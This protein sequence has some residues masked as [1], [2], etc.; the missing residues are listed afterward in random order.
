LT[1]VTILSMHE[2]GYIGVA[3]LP[4]DADIVNTSHLGIFGIAVG[5]SS[6]KV[7]E[8]AWPSGRSTA[9][10]SA[11]KTPMPAALSVSQDDANEP[12][13]LRIWLQGMLGPFVEPFQQGDEVGLVS[14]NTLRCDRHEEGCT[15]CVCL[16][17]AA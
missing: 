12:A 15:S 6:H 8:S 3:E 16:S 4:T 10:R 5:A 17:V 1:V 14:S 13:R 11:G 2:L 7:K 9:A